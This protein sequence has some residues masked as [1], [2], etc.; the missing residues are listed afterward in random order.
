MDDKNMIKKIICLLVVVLFCVGIC[1]CS[2][3]M[4][5]Q[6]TDNQA[7]MFV[8]LENFSSASGGY[9]YVV[10]HKD[11]KVMYIISHDGIATVMVNVE[12]KPLLWKG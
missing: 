7:S 10:Y 1:G 11:T 3:T 4:E 12:G 9:S 2:A 6:T 5:D 8:K